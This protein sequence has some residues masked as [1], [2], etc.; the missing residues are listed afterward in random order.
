[1]TPRPQDALGHFGPVQSFTVT[2]SDTTEYSPPLRGILL[3]TAGA[4]KVGYPDGTTDTFSSG[5]LTAGVWHPLYNITKVFDTDT[6][7]ITIHCG[8]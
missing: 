8:R 6:D 3:E 1:M 4:V 5:A 7:A 2:P